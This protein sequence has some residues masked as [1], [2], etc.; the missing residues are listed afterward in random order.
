MCTVCHFITLRRSAKISTRPLYSYSCSYL[1]KKMQSY[2]RNRTSRL[3]H[4][5]DNRITDGGEA[6]SLTAGCPLP[7][8]RF[9]VLI[10]AR[11]WVDPRTIVWLEGLRKLKKSNDHN[12]N[13]TRDLPAC[14]IVPQPP[15]LPRAPPLCFYFSFPNCSEGFRNTA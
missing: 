15:T 12:G 13:R 3:P 1:T 2:P 11:G 7:P 4:F 8:G 10:S 6:V 5:L 14:S 9:L